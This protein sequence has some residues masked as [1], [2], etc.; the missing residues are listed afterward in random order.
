M[1]AW[2]FLISRNRTIDYKVIVAPDFLVQIGQENILANVPGEQITEKPVYHKLKS[3]VGVLD[4]IF[5][6]KLAKMGQSTLRDEFGRPILWTE[7]LVFQGNVEGRRVA[8]ADFHILHEQ[9]QILFKSFWDIRESDFEVIATKPL[10]I[11]FDQDHLYSEKETI[12]QKTPSTISG[13][14]SS[15]EINHQEHYY[16]LEK[17]RERVDKNYKIGLVCSVV[18][19]PLIALGIGIVV[20][21]VGGFVAWQNYH[22][23]TELDEQIKRLKNNH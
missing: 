20:A 7:G 17:E 11:T 22:K 6:V 8:E 4:L 5:M 16:Q 14:W 23:R 19:I 21:P 2:P 10:E 3:D 18:G 13:G 1:F 15:G 12:S 9:M